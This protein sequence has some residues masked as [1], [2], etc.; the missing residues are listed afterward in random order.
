MNFYKANTSCISQGA[1]L[2]SI[3]DSDEL[4]FLDTLLAKGEK[5]F[6]G[7]TDIAE[8]GRWVWMDGSVPK[9]DPLWHGNHP[10]GGDEENCGE[11]VQDH[12][13]HDI[14][15]D[16]TRPYVCKYSLHDM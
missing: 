13:F 6:V 10:D 8:E 15:C 16:D 14:E 3:E 2:V 1:G 5:V 7:M 11:Y 4:G 9:L 12:G